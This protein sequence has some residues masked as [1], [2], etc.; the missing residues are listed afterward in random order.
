[1]LSVM[2]AA[3]WS[4]LAAVSIALCA[5]Q[6]VTTIST[7]A[8]RAQPDS[9][10]PAADSAVPTLD[11]AVPARAECAAHTD[12]VL[13][14]RGCCASCLPPTREQ[15]LAVPK[16]KQSETQQAQCPGTVACGPCATDDPEPLSPLLVAACVAQRCQLLDLRSDEISV[17]ER[18]SDCLPVSR[19]C[20]PAYSA[21]PA[22]Y[23]GIH[24]GADSGLLACF[25]IPPCIP[26]DPHPEPI[27]FCASD[28]HCAVRRR[29]TLAG[30]ESADCYTPTQNLDRAYDTGAV[31][32]DC[33]PGSSP[34]CR[35]DST[36]RRV[37]LICQDTG[38]WASAEDG[39]C[40][41]LTP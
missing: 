1:M 19:S 25:P 13:V 12:C 24:D 7:D 36:G 20:C 27:A 6:P 23:V 4:R 14:G 8:G 30:V 15:V 39:P 28:K 21:A 34:V 2:H 3:L 32:C 35:S 9:A 10:V 37:A 22:D 11:S 26:P 33:Q 16:S 29:E 38:R 18:D 31:G 41:K 17:C 5:C 40:A